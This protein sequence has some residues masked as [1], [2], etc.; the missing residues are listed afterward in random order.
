[1][2]YDFS[3]VF[4]ENAD[5]ILDEF[6]DRYTTYI[7]IDNEDGMSMSIFS[8][9]YR[10]ILNTFK[11]DFEEESI[12]DLFE[13]VAQYE[14]SIKMPYI[15]IINELFCLK[16]LLF[17]KITRN[18]GNHL[19][20]SQMLTL[21]EK[22]NNRVAKVYLYKYIDLMLSLNNMRRASISDLVEKK[23]IK[24]Y[25]DH[26]VWLTSLA[27][28]VKDKN[29]DIFPELEETQCSFGKWLNNDGKSI[30]QNNSKYDRINTLHNNLHKFAQK[31]FMRMHTD[32]FDIL[33]T[34]LE[35][36]ELIS[37]S[38][39]TELAMIDNILMNQQVTKDSLTDALNRNG[40]KNVFESQYE[41]SFATN[42]HFVLAMCDLDFFKEINDTY[43]HV[44][45]D[46][47]LVHFVNIVKKNIRNS[48]I[49]IRYGGEEFIVIL[50]A[51]N[52]EKGCHVLE[53]IRK[54]FQENKLHF[55]N[56]KIQATV[57]IGMMEIKPEYHYKKSFLNDY[58]MQVDQ[59]L[60]LAKHNGRNRVE[61][62]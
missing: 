48:D 35:K 51:I 32:K 22:I 52:K 10:D 2:A 15:A 11:S 56:K 46:K 5:M 38:I 9:H 16:H 49:I 31:I 17:A 4:K 60:Y 39:G 24:H 13:K 44:A 37:L 19:Y 6:L 36:C 43:G 58:L 7:E 29:L 14:I 21:F 25:E 1:M 27:Q 47:I 53:K 54:D 18:N 12:L 8:N 40:L 33:I 55:E 20:I 3:P 62:C 50:P 42:N 30:I 41:L 34:Y 26:L 45:G 59:K 57:S 28:S 23:T 61:S